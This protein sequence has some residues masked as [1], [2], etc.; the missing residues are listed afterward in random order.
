MLRVKQQS[1]GI[2]IMSLK[3]VIIATSSLMLGSFILSIWLA[4]VYN[5]ESAIGT[6]CKVANYLPSVSAAIS[7]QPSCYVWRITI[8]LCSPTRLMLAYM[9]FIYFYNHQ[10]RVN[11]SYRFLCILCVVFEISENLSLIGLTYISSRDLKEVHEKLFLIFQA[12]SMLFMLSMC[13]MYKQYTKYSDPEN[14]RSEKRTLYSKIS[15]LVV[16]ILSFLIAVYFFFRH[17]WYCETGVYTLFAFFEYIL[18]VANIVFHSLVTYN[19]VD[20]DVKFGCI[21]ESHYD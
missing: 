20:R 4:L 1:N 6:H 19:F 8:A 15:V 9:H 10:S 11:T 21:K 16:D 13:V 3:T 12:S 7:I 18:V 17:N 5:Y 2:V 14:A